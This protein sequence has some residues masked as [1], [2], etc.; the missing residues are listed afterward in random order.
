MYKNMIENLI[1]WAHALKRWTKIN[2]EGK[3]GYEGPFLLYIT[4]CQ[5]NGRGHSLSWPM[6]MR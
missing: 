3:M 6:S 2:A 1:M 4:Q 5:R